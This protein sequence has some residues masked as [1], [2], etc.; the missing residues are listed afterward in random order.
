MASKID[1]SNMALRRLG[2]ETITSLDASTKIARIMKNIYDI[3]RK[4]VLESHPWAFALKR[5]EIY[6]EGFENTVTLPIT[7]DGATV[8]ATFSN[9]SG[10]D[11]N[12]VEYGV[13]KFIDTT[14]ALTVA[15]TVGT[16]PAPRL[17]YIYLVG[18][19]LTA[20][21]S[22]FPSGAHTPIATAWISS[23]AKVQTSGVTAQFD[24]SKP[25]FE[26]SKK[27]YV[28]RDYIRA[29]KEYSEAV[30]K[31]E[32]DWFLGDADKL[33]MTYISDI[34]DEEKFNP[35]FVNVLYLNLA[36][37]ASYSIVQS[38]SLTREI[39]AEM[40]EVIAEARSFMSQ[41]STPDD[42]DF[43]HFNDIRL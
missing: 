10:G 20:S 22:G 31:R 2:A 1:I 17:N 12:Y 18:G 19:T 40:K 13:R 21:T 42:Y 28:P 8:T 39:R 35:L 23:A 24:F 25:L 7:S 16:D 29:W 41:E 9:A 15:L 37:E 14:P 38:Q 6:A 34:E 5:A 11:L 43:D 4:R 33:Q 32:G 27:Y 3:T 36:M 26:Y 30:H